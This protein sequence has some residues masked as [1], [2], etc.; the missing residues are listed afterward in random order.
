VTRG[1]V[2]RA[3]AGAELPAGFFI[4]YARINSGRIAQETDVFTFYLTSFAY[5]RN[6]NSLRGSRST[7][8]EVIA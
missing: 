6:P 5:N 7:H 1:T 3:P 8:E 2:S 4:R